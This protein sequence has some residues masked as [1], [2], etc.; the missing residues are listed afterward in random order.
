M[1]SVERILEYIR[2]PKEPL[3]EGTIKAVAEWPKKGHV[4]FRDVW[5][6]YDEKLT[7]V[8]KGLSVEIDPSEKVGIIG[9]TGAGKSSFIQ[10]LFRLYEPS[11][12]ILIDDV[13][14]QDLSLHDLRSR[15]TIIPV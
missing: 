11:G 1:T 12:T 3:S 8:L 9:R 5:L 2:L 4:E 14:I 15:L 13:N 6:R 10:T 7:H